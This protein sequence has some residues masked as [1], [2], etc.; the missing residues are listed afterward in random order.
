MKTKRI[1]NLF[2]NSIDIFILYYRDL[3]K[4]NLSVSSQLE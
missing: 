4:S 3:E 1:D 2:I